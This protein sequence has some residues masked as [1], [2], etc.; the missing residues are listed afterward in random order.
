MNYLAKIRG[1]KE[2]KLKNI[3]EE[4][5]KGTS[6]HCQ[7]ETSEFG[8][9]TP[10]ADSDITIEPAHPPSTVYW[11]SDGTI[12]GPASVSYVAKSRDQFYLCLEWQGSFRWVHESLLRSKRDFEHQ[13]QHICNCCGRFE[14]WQSIHGATICGKC[15]PPAD[16]SLVKGWEFG[17]VDQ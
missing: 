5:K 4:E 1:I 17:R 16:T 10:V 13:G 7:G 8:E 11:E 3:L 2:E 14:F 9:T 12:L 15:H 6:V